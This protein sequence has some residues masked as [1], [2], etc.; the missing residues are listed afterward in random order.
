MVDNVTADPGSGGAVFATDEISSV[1]YPITKIT[2]GGLDSQTI[3]SS[4][5]GN[6]D[7]GTQR[8]VLATDQVVLSVDD[9]GGSLTVDNSGTFAVQIDG[10]NGTVD[11]N[12]NSSTPLAGGATFTGTATDILQVAGITISVFSDVASATDGLS[13][14]FSSDGTNWD[15]L[16]VFTIPAV[17]GKTFSFQP[18]AKWM[19]VLYTNGASAQAEFRLSVILK[20]QAG[21]PSSHRIAD[22]IVGQDDA[23][24][25]KAVI[26]AENPSNQFVNVQA[27]TAGNF[28]V[29]IEESN[30]DITGPGTE[31]TA[32]RVTMAT[33]STGL[34]SVDDN[35]GSLTVDN[36]GTFAVQSTLQAGT[37]EIG[38]LAAGVAEIGNV[39]NSGTFIVQEDGAALTS[40][41]LI[42]DPVFADDAA[43]TLAS[44]KTMVAGAIRDDHIATLSAAEGDVVPLRVNSLGRLHVQSHLFD[45]G[46]VDGFGH[47]LMNE[48]VNQV[49]AQFFRDTPANLL[50]V[51]T[52]GGGATSQVGGAGKFETSTAT[53][54]NAKGVTTLT[55]S[56]RSASEV[57]VLYSVLFTTPTDENG[58][59]RLGL[60]D[61]NDGVFIG[62]EGT[63]FGVTIRNA[64]SDTQTAKASFSEDTL[65]GATGSMFTR[66]GIPEAI[67]LTK[68]N[69][70]R[71]R[72]GWLGSAP[73]FFEV[74]TP[75][76]EWITFHTTR[77]PNNAV[78]A[79]MENPD[80]PITAHVSKT[81]ADATNL[82]ILTNC[83]AA[84]VTSGALPLNEVLTDDNLAKVTRNVIVGKTAGG[85]YVN[86]QTTNSGNFKIALDEYDGVP[87]G[88]GVEAGSLRV[89]LAN[90]STGQV[91]LAAGTAGIGKLTAN[92]GVDIGDVDVTSIAAGSNLIGD[93][94]LSGARTS[95]GTTLYKNIDVDESEDEVKATA[96]QVYWIHAIN[97]TAAPL[98][99]K[100][101][102]L[103]AASVT[104][105]TT[106]PDLTFPV[107]GN[108][109]SDG[110]GFT[111]SIPNGIEFGTGITIAATTAV[112]DNDAGAPSGNALV[113]NLGFA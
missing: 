80:L 62:F 89:T 91:K 39:K 27:T 100:F 41:Q 76:G 40:L 60:Y 95:G 37:A 56:Y 46:T 14:Q 104:V 47:L 81:A 34:L 24:V 69:V 32:L 4:G 54:A 77:Q 48:A 97:S 107:P 109:D 66:N 99:L 19:R 70:F 84:G 110:A 83:W 7:A 102:N 11:T 17:T 36:D 71:M 10:I 43:F 35:G 79:S 113:V 25:V 59:Q 98:F 15:H 33:D 57:F 44:S 42:D 22:M 88:G 31:A 12:N 1:H 108:A 3:A 53:T 20:T 16:D 64:A 23:E 87:I 74:L 75:D 106:V 18:V 26:T 38:K 28:K 52:A 6:V 103:A 50:T 73:I 2:F 49:E 72:W 93:V 51:T 30:G 105:G 45:P 13:V 92:S 112:A 8:V 68:F 5:A 111:L 67:D 101:Y 29:S 85:S 61:D 21:K 86:V 96:G 82:I 90:D 55:T 63:T 9:N 58:F 65:V 78:I 94:G